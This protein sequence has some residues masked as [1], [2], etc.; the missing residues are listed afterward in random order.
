VLLAE[1]HVLLGAIER[2]PRIDAPLQRATDVRVEIGMTPAQLIQNAD[3]A[4]PGR[5]L[6]DRHDV[7]VPIGRQW[8]GST[9][10]SWRLLLR[11]QPWIDLDPI[12]S[13]RREP[14]LGRC[15][16]G[17]ECLSV[18]HVQPHLVVVDVEA[19][20]AL[21]PRCRDESV[22][23]PSPIRPPDGLE[24]RDAGGGGTKGGRSPTVVLPPPARSHPDCRWFSP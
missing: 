17:G 22:A 1:D 7:D 5:R 20:Q 24:K 12:P 18:T 13:R 21:I 14:H 9:P 19:G 2:S 8:I 6:Q 4:D 11:R 15:G 16:Y 10:S 3:H 23:W